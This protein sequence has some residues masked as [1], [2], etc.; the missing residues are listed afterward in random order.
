M[1]AS[2]LIDIDEF[3]ALATSR[4]H[5]ERSTDPATGLSGL[6]DAQTGV[7]VYLEREKLHQARVPIEG[8][9]DCQRRGC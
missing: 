5:L 8:G 6:Y 7:T 4:R 1:T 9:R 2:R 3:V